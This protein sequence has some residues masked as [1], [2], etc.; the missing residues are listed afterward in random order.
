MVRY[1]EGLIDEIKVNNDIVDII[2]QYV[3]LKR[4]GRNFSGLCP[5][6][7]EKT[8]SFSVSPDKQIFHCFGC[9]VGGDVITFICKIE[10]VNYREAI[11]ILAEK[12]GITL[13]TTDNASEAK[14]DLL[15]Q[16]VFEI[17][18]LIANFYHQNLYMPIAK[19][20]QEYV[21]KRKLDNNTLKKFMIG[22]STGNNEVYKLLKNKGF[23]EEQILASNLVKK[24]SYGYNDVYKN[25]LMFPIQDIRN[26]YIAFGGRVLDNSLPKYINSPEGITYSKGRNLYAMNIAKNANMG[27]IIMVEGYMDAVSLHQRGIPNV[28]ASLGTALTEGQAR[29]LRKYTD[30][31]VISYDSDGA[32]QAATLRGLEILKNVGCDVRILQMEGAKDPDEYVIK[33]GNGRFNLLVQNAISLIEFKVKVLKKNLDLNNI[34]DKIKFLKETAKLITTINSKIEQEI[35]I[36]KIANEYNISKEALYAEI[37]KTN[38]KIVTTKVLERKP[39]QVIKKENVDKKLIER[40]KAIIALLIKE[41]NLWKRIEKEIQL[42]D[43]KSEINKKILKKLYEE[44]EKGNSNINNVLNYFINDEETMSR[45]T[46]IMAE[47]YQIDN[48]EKAIRNVINT[49]KIEKLDNRKMELLEKEQQPNLSKEDKEKIIEEINKIIIEKKMIK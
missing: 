41:K 47:E 42:N 28:V 16:K 12:A 46:E 38:N 33:Y 18:E 9:G 23:T 8:P 25:R 34:N 17:N 29:L 49:Y 22:Y 20:A 31:V 35:Y 30:K 37:N 44:Y 24:T 11:E 4:S 40:E 15:R 1:S 48:D 26:R 5:F 10:N 45:L 13:P 6:H 39:R 2:S 27:K 19:T 14:R 32:G 43:F 3:V 36:D 21:K 7:K